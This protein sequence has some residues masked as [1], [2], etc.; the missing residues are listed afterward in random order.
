MIRMIRKGELEPKD[1]DLERVV[2]VNNGWVFVLTLYNI[3]QLP[4]A[5]I[6]RRQSKRKS[7]VVTGVVFSLFI[8][9]RVYR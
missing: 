9:F 8:R 3:F 5:L 2:M 6:H 4:R 7:G 1:K